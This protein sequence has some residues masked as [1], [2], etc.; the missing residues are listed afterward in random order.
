MVKALFDKG[1]LI[2]FAGNTVLRFLPPLI[3]TK[4]EID[5]LLA[6]LSEV[7]AECKG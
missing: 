1:V 5:Q 3:I 7:L 6:A 4:A 2:N